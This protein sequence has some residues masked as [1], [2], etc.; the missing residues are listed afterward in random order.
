[1]I[2]LGIL[3]AAGGSTALPTFI[4]LFGKITTVNIPTNTASATSSDTNAV[5]NFSIEQELYYDSPN[6]DQTVTLE[7]TLLD[8]GGNPVV[9]QSVYFVLFPIYSGSLILIGTSSLG[10]GTTETMITDSNGKISKE[11]S[12][13]E[14]ADNQYSDYTILAAFD[15]N[16]EGTLANSSS[17]N[18][19]VILSVT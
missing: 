19:Q 14:W 16:I 9:G 11:F 8:G 3:S 17:P 1:M 13:E 2:P 7:A 5:P 4:S 12:S 10:A 6:F 15:G 18:G